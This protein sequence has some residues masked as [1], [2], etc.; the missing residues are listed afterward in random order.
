ML[1]I[2][3]IFQ[4]EVALLL[5]AISLATLGAR[6][7]IFRKQSNVLR[8][9]ISAIIDPSLT[10]TLQNV[11]VRF[12]IAINNPSHISTRLVKLRP[13]LPP[14]VR[15]TG[16]NAIV[17]KLF[18]SN[19][20]LRH[21]MTVQA[22]ASGLF[23][24][25]TVTATIEDRSTLF[26]ESLRLSCRWV[27]ET[28]PP[29][30]F[31]PM[32]MET[33]D[34][35]RAGSVSDIAGVREAVSIDD[36]RTIDWKT[37]ARTGKFMAKQFYRE[38]T[39]PAIIAVDREVL[40]EGIRSDN[41]ALLTVAELLISFAPL[42]RIGLAIYDADKVIVYFT[43]TAGTR[44]LQQMVSALVNATVED[45][46]E[47]GEYVTRLYADLAS[48]VRGLK[49]TMTL[50]PRRSIDV[51]ARDL[52]PY[53]EEALAKHPLKLRKDGAFEA[54][55]TISEFP[56][57]ALVIVISGFSHDLTGL[58]EGV[59][60]TSAAGHYVAVSVIG[61]RESLS[62]ELSE[63]QQ[64]GVL[65][66]QGSGPELLTAISNGLQKAQRVKTRTIKAQ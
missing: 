11:P 45:V 55:S 14:Q 59:L 5:A 23:T 7:A 15:D 36:F 48:M 52:L 50:R 12:T 20:T 8:K 44:V 29:L 30:T 6:A 24:V 58:C 28:S 66:V 43:P 25:S 31:A 10:A 53:Y 18:P 56:Q 37:T 27:L 19:S 4:S 35:R 33:T 22:A 26:T 63:L 51:F 32:R 49:S 21:E 47:P 42:T 16:K 34:P 62:P 64:T 1:T 3:L 61:G 2:G 54:L 57:S 46:R 60:T 65:I 39:P 40:V 41:N 38:S 13:T 9:N 17:P